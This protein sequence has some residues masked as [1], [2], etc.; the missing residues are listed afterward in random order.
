MK[1]DVFKYNMRIQR[2][3]NY[4][5]IALLIGRWDTCKDIRVEMQNSFTK[6]KSKEDTIV[7][8]AYVKQAIL[9]GFNIMYIYIYCS[10]YLLVT[11][12]I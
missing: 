1:A 3:N 8:V 12:V 5:K 2:G 10:C 7:S 9:P 6:W 4:V 11:A